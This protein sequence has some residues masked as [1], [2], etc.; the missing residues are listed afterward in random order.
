M[1]E[2]AKMLSNT[3]GKK[4]ICLE[5][6]QLNKETNTICAR[7]YSEDGTPCDKHV[8]LYNS[9]NHIAE[10]LDILTGLQLPIGT[11]FHISIDF[12]VPEDKKDNIYKSMIHDTK[13]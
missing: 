10:T 2:Q 8:K 6:I 5:T 7:I 13:M 4:E 1:I 3:Q 12:D 11:K 9:G